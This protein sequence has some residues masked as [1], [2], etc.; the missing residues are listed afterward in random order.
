MSLAVLAPLAERP[1][2]QAHREWTANTAPGANIHDFGGAVWWAFSTVTTVGYG[3][4]FPVTTAGRAVAG[5]LMVTGVRLFGVITAAVAAWFVRPVQPET[6]QPAPVQAGPDVAAMAA[7]MDRLETL[8]ADL[9]AALA[10]T[11]VPDPAMKT[12][13][14]APHDQQ[15]RPERQHRS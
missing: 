11:L 12:T 3:D 8:I 10:L 5:L 9:P 6:V 15:V 14:A 1:R 2:S 4:R 13:R 7:R